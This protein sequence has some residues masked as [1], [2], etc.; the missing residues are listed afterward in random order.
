MVNGYSGYYPPSYLARL[1]PMNKIPN[2]S[3]VEALVRAGVRYVIVHPDLFDA[4]RRDDVLA[5]ISS[6]SQFIE[7]GQF[8]D[9]L[10]AAVVFRLR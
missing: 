9:G 2:S 7:L 3:A 8:H 6:S 5:D 10:G 4:G 1:G